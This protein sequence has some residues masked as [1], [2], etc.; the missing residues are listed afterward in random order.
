M[1]FAV[2]LTDIGKLPGLLPGLKSCVANPNVEECDAT[3]PHAYSSCRAHKN[4]GAYITTR[5][6]RPIEE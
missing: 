3:M 1:L 4:Y 5:L 6:E 2:L